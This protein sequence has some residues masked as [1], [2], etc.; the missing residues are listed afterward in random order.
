MFSGMDLS[1]CIVSTE[2]FEWGRYGGIGKATREIGAG[3]T[4]RGVEVAV[5]IPRGEGQRAVEEM[6]GMRVHGFPMHAYPFT[7]GIYRECDADVY[8]SQEPS[9]GSIL[10]MKATP[11]RKHAVTCQNPKSRGDWGI[12][13]RFYP[14][15]RRIFNNIFEGRLRE[16]VRGMDGVYCQAHFM[17][18]KVKEL[19]GLES[20]PGFLPNPVEVPERR[21]SKDDDP[22]VCFLARFDGEKRPELFFELAKKFPDVKFVALGA[23]HNEERNARLRERYSG[24]D[25]LAMPGFVAL[26]QKMET[27]EC[28]WVLVNSSVSEGLP[29]SF[30]EAAAHGCAILS[31]LDPE[32]FASRFGAHVGDSDLESGLR[33]LLEGNRWRELGETGRAYVSEAHEKE[34]VIDLHLE[35]YEA[36]LATR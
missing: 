31:F 33:W 19:Y 29:V 24:I 2:F 14:L 21:P 32:G 36:L 8:H 7:Q 11:R 30:L 22:T 18:P 28:S 25:N 1:V 3:L 35:A 6:D 34:R 27:L 5:V 16:T 9:W 10:A 13:N 26:S 4:E 23:S 17:R 12:V 15:R 20:D